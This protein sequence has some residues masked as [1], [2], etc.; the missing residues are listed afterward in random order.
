M[1]Y[2]TYGC[3]CIYMCSM[4]KC[5]SAYVCLVSA[6]VV[7]QL[8][9]PSAVSC[10]TARPWRGTYLALQRAVTWALWLQLMQ[11][12]LGRH[13]GLIQNSHRRIGLCKM[14]AR[15]ITG[16]SSHNNSC[17][18]ERDAPIKYKVC[19]SAGSGNGICGIHYA[20]LY[21]IVVL[22]FFRNN[23]LLS[24]SMERI[25]AMLTFSPVELRLL[26]RLNSLY[27][28]KLSH[29]FHPWDSVCEKHTAKFTKILN[30]SSPTTAKTTKL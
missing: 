8:F 4:A 6:W 21:R 3:S 9:L 18:F 26:W 13:L 7:Y 28:D 2:G 29:R 23:S 24:Y 22:F 10:Y 20:V 12:D 16:T 27:K 11:Q 15:T 30:S 1:G 19:W 14:D 17:S 5:P 25:P